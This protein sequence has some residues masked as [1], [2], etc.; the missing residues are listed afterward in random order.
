MKHFLASKRSQK[1][2]LLP[3]LI[4]GLI[5]SAC[6]A[7]ETTASVPDAAK[8]NVAEAQ[9]APQNIQKGE[10][11]ARYK[12]LF[13]KAKETVAL[14]LR[15]NPGNFRAE[16]H[17]DKFPARQAITG[18]GEKIEIAEFFSYGCGHCFNS[19]PYMQAYEGLVADDVD[20]VR[21]PA[22]F[23]QPFELLARA[24]YVAQALG[25]DEEAHIAIFDAIHI[26]KQQ[27]LMRSESA[28][29]EFYSAYGIDKDQF[30]K[31]LHS[32]SINS[33]IERDRK[34]AQAYQVSGVPTII[35]NGA[36]N[37]GGSKAGSYSTWFQIL[38]TLTELE[39][40]EKR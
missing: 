24:Y 19:E 35:V 13:D 36:Y 22:S 4:I 8:V 23:N 39:R 16:V 38:D 12:G 10:V 27:N 37:T 20:F 17:Y 2:L 6:S 1:L 21:I 30:K 5:S 26:K 33:L 31:S 7:K 25:A 3:I 32:F 14:S 34:L 40:N 15:E 18:S 9:A 11:D 28:L 29:A